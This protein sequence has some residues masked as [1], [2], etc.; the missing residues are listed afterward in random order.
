MRSE[1]QK[2]GIES[3]I[4]GG[5]M[6]KLERERCAATTWAYNGGGEGEEGCRGEMMVG[7]RKR[8]GCGGARV[9]R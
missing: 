8:D 7:G 9:S 1:P 4:M 3:R 6:N 2:R 5:P